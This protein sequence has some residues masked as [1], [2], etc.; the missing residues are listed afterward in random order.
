MERNV[1]HGF[2]ILMVWFHIMGI[3]DL[4]V[5]TEVG[6]PSSSALGKSKK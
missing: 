5:W 2:D 3:D 1:Q 4:M 6:H